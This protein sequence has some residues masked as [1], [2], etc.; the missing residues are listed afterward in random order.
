MDNVGRFFKTPPDSFFLFGPRGTGKSTLL[1]ENFPDALF[2]D[3]LDF[4]SDYFKEV[5]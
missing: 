4:G 3:L 2:V 1:K 5:G